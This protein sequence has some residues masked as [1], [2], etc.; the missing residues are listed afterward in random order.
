MW[1]TA[2]LASGVDIFVAAA[3]RLPDFDFLWIGPWTAEADR[4]LH[5]RGLEADKIANLYCT[6]ACDNPYYFIGS[7]S[8]FAATASNMNMTQLMEVAALGKP[9]LLFSESGEAAKVLGNAVYQFHGQPDTDRL[10]ALLPKVLEG[11]GKGPSDDARAT[12][13]ADRQTALAHL[14]EELKRRAIW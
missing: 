5:S 3:E 1:G 8:L 11:R 2:C 6:G 13:G 14:I 7:C 9:I 10:V 4:S 12:G